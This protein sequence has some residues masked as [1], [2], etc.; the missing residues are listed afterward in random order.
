MARRPRRSIAGWAS[1]LDSHAIHVEWCCNDSAWD[2]HASASGGVA[3]L[4]PSNSSAHT[5]NVDSRAAD[6]EWYCADS[7]RD[8]HASTDGGHVFIRPSRNASVAPRSSD[9][10]SRA[11]RVCSAARSSS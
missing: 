5:N 10:V 8:W 9:H 6:A 1:D 7:A 2:E 3:I 4:F 11:W